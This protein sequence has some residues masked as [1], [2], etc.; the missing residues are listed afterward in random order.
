VEAVM[1]W[2]GNGNGSDYLRFKGILYRLGGEYR[3]SIYSDFFCRLN[4]ADWDRVQFDFA[5]MYRGKLF[6]VE[7][8]DEDHDGRNHPLRSGKEHACGISNVPLRVFYSNDLWSDDIEE[9]ILGFVSTQVAGKQEVVPSKS[10]WDFVERNF[11]WR[12]NRR[13]YNEG[14]RVFGWAKKYVYV[15]GG[16]RLN[17]S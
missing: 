11:N 4:G 7:F 14:K 17:P 3:F 1:G 16:Y 13:Y 5:I 2:C 10:C 8:D 15:N 12:Q 9:Q 6:L